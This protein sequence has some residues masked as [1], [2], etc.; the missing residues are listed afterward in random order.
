M[1]NIKV[2]DMIYRSDDNWKALPVKD[3]PTEENLQEIC[4]EEKNW[5]VPLILSRPNVWP[6]F[7]G[8]VYWHRL[9]PW[10]KRVDD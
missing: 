9:Y 8:K 2:D 6:N 3:V 10:Q 1:A 4:G 5:Q 7:M